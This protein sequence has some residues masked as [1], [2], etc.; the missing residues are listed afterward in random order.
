MK[1]KHSEINCVTRIINQTWDE[2]RACEFG[3]FCNFEDNQK[4]EKIIKP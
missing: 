1:C 3:V 4:I 2:F